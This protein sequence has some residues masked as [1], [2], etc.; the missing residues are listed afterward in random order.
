M[1]EPSHF[2]SFHDSRRTYHVTSTMTIFDGEQVCVELASTDAKELGKLKPVICGPTNAMVKL[3]ED[4]L[5]AVTET[6]E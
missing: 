4:I 1:N 3:A 6:N 2:R 5:A